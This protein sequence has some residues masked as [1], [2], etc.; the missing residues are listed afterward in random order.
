MQLAKTTTTDDTQT[1]ESHNTH[2]HELD[3]TTTPQPQKRQEEQH[4]TC[5]KIYP[6]PH[7]TY[8]RGGA[9]REL[10][11]GAE[12]RE[13][14]GG[15]RRRGRGASVSRPSSKHAR[16]AF[17]PPACARAS[18]EAEADTALAAAG[19][20]SD[21]MAWTSSRRPGR[22]WRP[23][24][25]RRGCARHTPKQSNEVNQYFLPR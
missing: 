15:S 18:F 20:G 19:S 25:A 8:E 14:G 7:T 11:R 9:A 13:R 4:A 5:K 12:S 16:R 6:T 22:L 21:A 10:E 24:L 17:S 3:G 2:N 23:A 1:Q